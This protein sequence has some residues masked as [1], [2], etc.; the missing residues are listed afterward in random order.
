MGTISLV[1]DGRFGQTAIF[2]TKVFAFS[3]L[4]II[5]ATVHGI[6]LAQITHKDMIVVEKICNI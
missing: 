5:F 4:K 6:F 1:L 2:L 3:F